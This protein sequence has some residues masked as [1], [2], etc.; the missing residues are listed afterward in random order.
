[1]I[2]IRPEPARDDDWRYPH[3]R[4]R[5]AMMTMTIR[6]PP[7]RKSPQQL[8]AKHEK[9]RLVRQRL[10]R[11]FETYVCVDCGLV[12]LN[13]ELRRDLVP[14][15]NANAKANANTLLLGGAIVTCPRQRAP[16]TNQS[17]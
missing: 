13:R 15:T 10:N 8:R 4:S 17:P 7:P 6:K 5:T 3:P 11:S 14:T 16:T 9:A 1:M 12:R 2:S